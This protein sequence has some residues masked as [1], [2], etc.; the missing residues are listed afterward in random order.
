MISMRSAL[1]TSRLA[2]R[3]WRRWID[4]T[5]LVKAMSEFV[6]GPAGDYMYRLD[7][8]ARLP[9]ICRRFCSRSSEAAIRSFD[10]EFFGP[11]FGL[12]ITVHVCVVF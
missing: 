12:Y 8:G 2:C 3:S 10:I 4:K 6:T 7:S 9:Q 1:L 5:D 11:D